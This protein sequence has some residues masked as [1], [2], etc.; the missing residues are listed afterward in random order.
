[1]DQEIPE[2]FLATEGQYNILYFHRLFQLQK[3]RSERGVDTII[4]G[5]GGELFKDVWWLQDFP[6]YYSRHSNLERLVDLRIMC[7]KPVHQML[8]ERYSLRSGMLRKNL[9]QGLSHYM[10]PRNTETYD[11]IFFNFKMRE[12]AGR[13]LTNYNSYVKAYAPFLDLDMARA[14]FMLPRAKRIYN[15]YH[16]KELTRINPAVAK[17]PT[18]EGGISASSDMMMIMRD[19]P[20]YLGE[21]MDRLLTKLKVR[22]QKRRSYLTHPRLYQHVRSLNIMEDSITS[23]KDAGIINKDV[24]TCKLEDGHL[25]MLLS[26]GMLV[27]RLQQRNEA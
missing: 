20:K 27:K 6:F 5:V 21:K 13:E 9:I 19:L 1:M 8:T 11:N 3:A 18:T 24:E 10:L 25:G 17:M 26:L 2:L 4:S 15:M 22:K 23:L 12:E 14:G 16:R 7:L